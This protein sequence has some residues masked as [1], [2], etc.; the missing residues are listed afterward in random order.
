MHDVILVTGGA[1]FIGSNFVLEWLQHEPAPVI[2]LD[3]LTYAGN[4]ENLAA[5]QDQARHL[6]IQGSIGDRDLV[7]QIFREHQPC[8]VVHFAAESHVDR[9]IHGPQDFIHTNV[10]GTF[11][12]LDAARHY[13]NGL[14]PS[15]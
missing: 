15:D 13:W 11:E 14:S 2:N 7:T 1:G 3:C 5:I 9:S 8:A 10:L 6:L 4:P 12:L